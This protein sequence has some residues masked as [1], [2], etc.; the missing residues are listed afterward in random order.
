[1]CGWPR[2]GRAAAA[3]GRGSGDAARTGAGTQ[4]SRRRGGSPP[5]TRR[6]GAASV[7]AIGTAAYTHS[8]GL[9]EVLGAALSDHDLA[10]VLEATDVLAHGQAHAAAVTMTAAWRRR[11]TRTARGWPAPSGE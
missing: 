4:G 3:P 8:R 1:M 9:G 7:L 10:V 6:I 2:A 11:P 5:W